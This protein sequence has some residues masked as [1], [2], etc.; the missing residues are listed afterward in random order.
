MNTQIGATGAQGATGPSQWVSMNGVG[1]TGFG[2][3]GIG[4]TGQDV[5]IYGNLLVTGAIDPTSISFSNETSGPTGSI[6]Y[7]TTN[8][9]RMNNMKINNIISDGAISSVLDQNVLTN[10]KT[11]SFDANG[12]SLKRD[13]LTTPIETTIT[14]LAITD[15]NTGNSIT[16]DR[17]TYLPIGLAALTVPSNPTTCNFN[18][19]IQI[20]DYNTTLAPPVNHSEAKLGANPLTFYGLQFTSTET[21]DT[22]ISNDNGNGMLIDSAGGLDLES[23]TS[24]TLTSNLLYN[25]NLDAP[26]VNSNSFSMPIC[27]TRQRTDN[28]SY[29]TGGQNFDLIYQTGFNIPQ[30]FVSISPM[31]IPLTSTNWKIDFAFNMFQVSNMADKGMGIY[32][33]FLDSQGNIY[34]PITYNANTPFSIDRKDF[35]YNSGGNGPYIPINWNDYVDLAALYNTSTNNFPFDMR[36]WFAADG[37]ISSNFNM[38]L[39]LTRTNLI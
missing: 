17:L 27:F 35:G 21:I 16:M 38:L 12:I 9:I 31:V 32:I 3:T 7:D 33:D 26:N 11:I 24:I 28:F 23:E 30:Q 34:T 22:T 5:L 15:V 39:T 37:S 6:W 18:D 25:I 10:T 2:Y 1:L 4:V 36:I 8:H 20:Q 19:A 14:S 29:S 13:L